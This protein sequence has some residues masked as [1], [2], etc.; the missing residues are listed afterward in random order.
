MFIISVAISQPWL[1]CSLYFQPESFYKGFKVKRGTHSSVSDAS[2]LAGKK[3]QEITS[4]W[5]SLPSCFL[6]Q[7][8]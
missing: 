2:F 6:L 3:T 5:I 1:S 8:T 4:R 7:S